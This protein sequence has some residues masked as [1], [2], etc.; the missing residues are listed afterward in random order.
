MTDATFISLVGAAKAADKAAL[1]VC[2][3][4]SLWM[5][6]CRV[7]PVFLSRCLIGYAAM[8]PAGD[9]MLFVTDELLEELEKD[10]D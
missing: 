8:Y 1:A 2:P 5:H 3:D 10:D 7:R 6:L 9:N 4:R